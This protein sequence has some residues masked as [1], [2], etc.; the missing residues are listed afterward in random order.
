MRA[1]ISGTKTRF[2]EAF[3]QAIQYLATN[4]KRLIPNATDKGVDYNSPWSQC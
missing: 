3:A 1:S 2:L 4:A